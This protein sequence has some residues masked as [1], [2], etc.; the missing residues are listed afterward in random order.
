MARGQGRGPGR[1]AGS[2][3][4]EVAVGPS[5]P[6]PTPQ[7]RAASTAEPWG[8][9]LHFLSWHLNLIWSH[10][11]DSGIVLV[12]Q[13]SKRADRSGDCC[14]QRHTGHCFSTFCSVFLH[15]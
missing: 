9:R 5:A 3:P 4:P 1:P 7:P 12:H 14:G 2:G 11:E 6:P 13:G 10:T 15:I 8:Q